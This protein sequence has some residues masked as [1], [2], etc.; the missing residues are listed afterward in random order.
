MRKSEQEFTVATTRLVP[1]L[2]ALESALRAERLADATVLDLRLVAEEILTN[3]A[4]YGHD[5]DAEHRA[6]MRLTL[7]A[8]ELTLE[9]RDDG[10]PFDPVA[11]QPTDLAAEGGDRPPGSLGLRLVLALVDSAA[12]ARV[13]SENV[14]TLKKRLREADGRMP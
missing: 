13:G 4:K 14:L 10:R 9:F 2:D 3:V 11:A 7:D 1:G 8:D 5:D 6:R 12:Y